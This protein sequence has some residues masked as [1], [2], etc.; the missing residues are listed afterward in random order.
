VRGDNTPDNARY[1]GYVDAND[2]YPDFQY[3]GYGEF[4]D[5]LMAGKIERPYL[6][7]NVGT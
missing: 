6:G 4:V 7:V 3:V 1:L 5:D 2:L